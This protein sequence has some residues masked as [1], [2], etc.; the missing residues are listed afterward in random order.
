MAA[1]RRALGG[2]SGEQRS[3]LSMFYWDGLS[4]DEIAHIFYIPAGTVK[5]RLHAARHELK[6]ILE[7]NKR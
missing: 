2:L 1:L 6:Q 7:R 3:M 4:I 5:S